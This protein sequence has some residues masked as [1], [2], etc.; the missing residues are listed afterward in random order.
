MNIIQEKLLYILK[1]VVREKELHVNDFQNLNE[2]E[3][4]ELYNYSRE[5]GVTAV[6]FKK[7]SD[8]IDNEPS[9][10][11]PSKNVILK[12]YMHF[13]SIEK[14]METIK[15]R[16]TEFANLMFN[17]GLKT[18]TLKGISISR[19]YPN[20][21]H[22]EFGDL[23]CFFL[24]FC[25]NSIKWD[26]A[27][28]KGNVAA[29]KVL[30]T[31][32]REHYKHSHISYKQ[33]MIENHQFCLPIRG[34]KMTKKLERHLRTILENK[35]IEENNINQSNLL[36]PPANFNALFLTAHAMNH[37][38]Y[39]GIKVRHLLDWALFLKVEY[40]NVDW[41]MFWEWCDK[42]HYSRFVMCLNEICEKFL[43]LDEEI[44]KVIE[45][46]Y[47]LN[48][49]VKSYSIRILE[50]IFSAVSIYNKAGSKTMIRF[51]IIRN[52]FNSSWKYKHIVQK[53]IT[54]ELLRQV[55]AMIW[56]R[57]PKL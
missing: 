30:A 55:A 18:L 31:V 52:F 56:D 1:S 2:K 11:K 36:Y 34:S 49:D 15:L 17:K 12:W 39:E 43:G 19:Y 44:V 27:Y 40:R 13:L 7:I 29:E 51:S 45:T 54:M 50:D 3:W 14:Q 21:L 4:F 35:L 26:N 46:K 5:Q 6:V 32:H 33:L 57:T 25:G 28:E 9:F 24:E 38:L 8:T 22:R 47:V 10:P 41:D 48:F 16:S 42:M 23:D 37:F 20:H 53:R